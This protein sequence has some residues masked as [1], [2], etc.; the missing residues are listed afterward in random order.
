MDCIFTV[1]EMMA[2]REGR[3]PGNI[4]RD[5]FVIKEVWKRLKLTHQRLKYLIV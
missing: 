2:S 5:V 1:T 4:C 3:S